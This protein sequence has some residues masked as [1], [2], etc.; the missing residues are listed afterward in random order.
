[1]KILVFG[2]PDSG[3]TTLSKKLV[4][5]SN[6]IDHYEAD[7]VRE[8]FNDWD[9]TTEG[10]QRQSDRMNSLAYLS[11]LNNKHCILDFICPLEKNRKDYD[12]KIFMDTIEK[13]IYEDTNDIFERPIEYDY[14][15]SNYNY[16]EV[17]KEIASG[18]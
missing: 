8:A 10:R 2:L 14:I 4:S 16:E 1:M 12:L 6:N 18:L 17:I 13:S 9:F 5:I 3:K 7:K 11:K 15:I